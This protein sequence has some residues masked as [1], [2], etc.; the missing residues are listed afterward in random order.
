M[1]GRVRGVVPA[2]DC[3]A[4]ERSK[5]A[6]GT[7]TVRRARHRLRILAVMS[8]GIPGVLPEAW[9][10]Y[11][12]LDVARLSALRDARVLGVAIVDD[13]NGPL[14][15]VEWMTTSNKR[16]GDRPVPLC[17]FGHFGDDTA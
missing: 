16:A 4:D 1:A 2:V 13:H 9:R 17:E 14:R 7:K 6:S 12:N 5:S 15:L 11:G 8:Q 10:C 3:V